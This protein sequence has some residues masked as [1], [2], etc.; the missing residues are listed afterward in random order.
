MI[1]AEITCAVCAFARRS[2]VTGAPLCTL[3]SILRALTILVAAQGCQRLRRC[4]VAALLR[5][6]PRVFVASPS[7]FRRCHTGRA[8]RT[9][10]AMLRHHVCRPLTRSSRLTRLGTLRVKAAGRPLG[11][12][13][14]SRPSGRSASLPHELQGFKAQVE[15]SEL[16]SRISRWSFHRAAR[17]AG[18]GTRT[19]AR[20]RGRLRAPILVC[21]RRLLS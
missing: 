11:S 19:G 13:G 6:L 18:V 17:V 21:A 2:T 4:A 8:S 10:P 14:S 16:L 5:R 20:P 1:A 3:E 7:P 12:Y 9:G 15:N